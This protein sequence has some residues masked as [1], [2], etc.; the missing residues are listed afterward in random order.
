MTINPLVVSLQHHATCP[1]MTGIPLQFERLL[2]TGSSQ[3]WTIVQ[4]IEIVKSLLKTRNLIR[5][6]LVVAFRNFSTA[7]I[8]AC[9]WQT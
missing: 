3:H 9:T 1:Y 2:Q 8:L 6:F 4:G 7:F 5:R